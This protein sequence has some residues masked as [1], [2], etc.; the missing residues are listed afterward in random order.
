MRIY[1]TA[2]EIK[3]PLLL[4]YREHL[5]AGSHRTALEILEAIETEGWYIDASSDRSRRLFGSLNPSMG[6]YTLI[7]QQ[8][9]GLPAT[10]EYVFSQPAT[11]EWLHIKAVL[12]PQTV[13]SLNAICN[14]HLAQRGTPP[15]RLQAVVKHSALLKARVELQMIEIIKRLAEKIRP[16]PNDT[17]TILGART[18]LRRTYP[19]SSPQANSAGNI[20]NQ[21]WHQDSNP[22]F[23]S[24]PLLT[25]WIPL[26][27]DSGISRPGIRV[28]KVPVSRFYADIGD[29]YNGAIAELSQHYGTIAVETPLVNAG[30]AVI[31]NGLTFHE[32]FSTTE[33]THHRDALL[34]R[35]VRTQEAKHFPTDRKNDIIVH[36]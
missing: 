21:S 15:K 24:R 20:H 33:M 16:A 7:R 29:G 6:F 11:G 28:M 4:K 25:L 9:S 8:F 12:D 26:Q 22:M 3:H 35:V 17:L 23:G 1:R 32:T 18:L 31:F 13:Q 2:N 19:I 5:V 30:D 10:S 34:V 27:P 14:N 36:F